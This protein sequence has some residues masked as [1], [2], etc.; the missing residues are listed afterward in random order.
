[1]N[2]KAGE[3]GLLREFTISGIIDLTELIQVLYTHSAMRQE[4]MW[5]RRP[6]SNSRPL[7]VYR[8]VWT[9]EKTPPFIC[10]YSC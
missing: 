5:G 2:K 10:R 8:N 3:K 9:K 4:Y 1:M 7:G 6:T